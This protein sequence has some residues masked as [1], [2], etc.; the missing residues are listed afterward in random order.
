MYTSDPEPGIDSK[1]VHR[2]GRT[3]ECPGK[4]S[5]NFVSPVEL[6]SP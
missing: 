2:V 5:H 3:C 6:L 4:P 1:H